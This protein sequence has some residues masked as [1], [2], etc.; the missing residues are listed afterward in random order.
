M[1][2]QEQQTIDKFQ[3]RYESGRIPWDHELPPPEVISALAERPA[4]RA[5]DL[6]C[7]LGRAAIYLA[8]RGWQVDAVDF[9]PLAIEQASQR[10]EAAGVAV[11]QV[12]QFVQGVKPH[13]GTRI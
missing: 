5:L 6:G 3:E 12:D 9:V 8:Q 10:A 7:G 1:D 2:E 4:G 11:V 13:G